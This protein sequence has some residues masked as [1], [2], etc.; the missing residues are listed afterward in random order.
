MSILASHLF[1]KRSRKALRE[2]IQRIASQKRQELKALIELQHKAL[3]R[4]NFKAEGGQ[5]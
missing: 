1:G 4:S 3:M 5:P 2:D